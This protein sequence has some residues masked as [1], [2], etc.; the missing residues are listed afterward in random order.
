MN[1]KD[2]YLKYKSKYLNY[3]KYLLSKK[4]LDNTIWWYDKINNWYSYFIY[5]FIYI[6][7]HRMELLAY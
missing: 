2:K 4:K 3:K 7:K 1:Y 5:T 6:W